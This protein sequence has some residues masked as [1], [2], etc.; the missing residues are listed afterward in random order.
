MALEIAGIYCTTSPSLS[1]AMEDCSI[2][3]VQQLQMLYRR[4]CCIVCVTTH[5]RLVMEHS[6]RSRTSTTRRQSS[7]RYDGKV[8][9]SDRT[10]YGHS[11]PHVMIEV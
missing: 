11:F 5:V 8:P 6:R 7:A 9:D 3:R 2:V 10:Q 4:R 1:G